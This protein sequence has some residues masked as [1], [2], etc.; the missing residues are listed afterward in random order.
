MNMIKKLIIVMV[1][2]CLA[3][4]SIAANSVIKTIYFDGVQVAQTVVDNNGLFWPSDRLMLG[5]DGTNFLYNQ[6]LGK[7]DDFAIYYG[8]LSQTRVEAHYN[9]RTNYDNY[10]SAVQADAPKM[11]L[12]FDDASTSNNSTAL[13]SG[14]VTSKNGTYVVTAGAINKL[15]TGFASGSG[16][17]EFVGPRGDNGNG[18]AIRIIDDACDFSKKS[19]GDISVEIWVNYQDSTNYGRFFQHNGSYQ[20][21]GAYG[22]NVNDSNSLV[23]WGGGKLNYALFPTDI[24]NGTWHHVVL[25]YDSTYENQP[26]PE[27]GTYEEEVSSDNPVAWLR[28]E[29]IL[30]VDSGIEGENHYVSYGSAASIVDKVGGIG[31]SLFLNGTSGS[32]VY[33]ALVAPTA[34]APEAVDSTYEVFNDSFAFVPGDATFEMWYKSLPT[35]QT[36]PATYAPFFQQI[37]DNE[38]C[39]P[40]AGNS[41]GSIRVFGGSARYTGVNSRFDQQWH[42]LVVAYDEQYGGN[43]QSMYMYLYLDGEL[44]DTYEFTGATA[45]LG[46]EMSHLLIGAANNIGYTYNAFA[47]YVDE[48]AIYPGVMSSQRVLMHYLAWRPQECNDMVQRGYTSPVDFNNDCKVNFQDFAIIA[49]NWMKCNDPATGCAANW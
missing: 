29:D 24:N 9:A 15:T 40:A 5:T 10:K 12:K 8:V 18:A 22:I 46:P 48:F 43:P 3:T 25:T 38:P 4:V 37:G 13:N 36:Q 45:R 26:L 27:T 11:W 31:K 32:G 17:I 20:K 30:P 16:A 33:G 34:T 14:S 42:H 1:L 6:Y 49:F 47:G 28:F 23:Y 7:M 2:S 41:D 21:Y 44:Q 39:G 35:D 19:N